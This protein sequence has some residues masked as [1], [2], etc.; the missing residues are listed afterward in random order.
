MLTNKQQQHTQKTKNVFVSQGKILFLY[1]NKVVG[2]GCFFQFKT[3]VHSSWTQSWHQ[4]ENICKNC[5]EKSDA[6]YCHR[7]RIAT[8]KDYTLPPIS[9]L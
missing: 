6:K 8:S 5:N 9:R 4:L 1:N 2:V 7:Q 3:R